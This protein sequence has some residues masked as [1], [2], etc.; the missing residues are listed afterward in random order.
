MA[1]LNKMSTEYRNED[2]TIIPGFLWLHNSIKASMTLKQNI[3]RT[4]VFY[5]N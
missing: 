2:S 5:Q 4:L 1:C 3:L